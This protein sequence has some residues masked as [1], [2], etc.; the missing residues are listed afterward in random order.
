MNCPLHTTTRPTTRYNPSCAREAFCYQLHDQVLVLLAVS[1]IVNK[2]GEKTT[3]TQ[4][5][6]AA[7]NNLEIIIKSARGAAG[8]KNQLIIRTE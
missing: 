1:G 7:L 2:A 4:D 5:W 6:H 8:K 3:A